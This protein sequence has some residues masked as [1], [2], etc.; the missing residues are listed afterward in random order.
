MS[1]ETI[2]KEFINQLKPKVFCGGNRCSGF[3][4]IE[5]DDSRH[6]DGRELV[7][8]RK[9]IMIIYKAIDQTKNETREETIREA[10]R[11]IEKIK[12]AVAKQ[13]GAFKYDGCYEDCIDI[14]NKLKK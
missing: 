2:L 10:I 12:I 8:I 11:K 4:N 9:V 7:D 6:P 14:L 13:A 3:H 5:C 1:K